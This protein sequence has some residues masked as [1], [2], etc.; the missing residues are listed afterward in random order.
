M[1]NWKAAPE[2]D[3]NSAEF[4]SPGQESVPP[5]S[6]A[7]LAALRARE[8]EEN[9]QSDP[10]AD[11]ERELTQIG[12]IE[13]FAIA[14]GFFGHSNAQTEVIEI[15]IEKAGE[16]ELLGLS[17]RDYEDLG[18]DDLEAEIALRLQD[19]AVAQSAE[20]KET[21]TEA[22]TEMEERFALLRSSKQSLCFVLANLRDEFA[23]RIPEETAL[24]LADFSELLSPETI[25]APK[26]LRAIEA[27]FDVDVGSN[28]A[29]ASFHGFVLAIYRQP[30][31]TVSEETK[32]RIEAK[33]EIPREPIRTGRE[34]AVATLA[35]SEDG[36]FVHDSPENSLE[37]RPGL[38]TFVDRDGRASISIE[39][40]A[41]TKPIQLSHEALQNGVAM[42][43]IANFAITRRAIFDEF[44]QLTNLFGAGTED[45][46]GTP[47]PESIRRANRFVTALIGSRP[48]DA[49]LSPEAQQS[50]RDALRA[51]RPSPSSSEEQ[52]RAELHKIG[53]LDSGDFAWTRVAEIGM[54]LRENS[55][56]RSF[57]NRAAGAANARLRL[58][59]D[60]RRNAAEMAA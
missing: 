2:S 33:F 36:A 55:Y 56:F 60:L 6:G 34:L 48:A 41:R 13:E 43:E 53:V 50:L 57:E 20:T 35:K 29:N 39:G 7:D 4:D 49:I 51:L 11:L 15:L 40:S 16:L 1:E 24:M 5:F 14:H 26:E 42:A 59:L 23:G 37:F 38:K 30:D 19:T 58:A 10:D 8:L 12:T 27:I 31:S 25:S 46:I 44:N 21:D 32:Q 47:S 52:V 3:L 17:L 22:I 28:L 54:V 18:T 45:A 9:D